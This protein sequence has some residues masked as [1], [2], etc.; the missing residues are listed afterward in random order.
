M[1]WREIGLDPVK[2]IITSKYWTTNH[3]LGKDAK[4]QQEFLVTSNK[5]VI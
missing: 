3:F 1:F 5:K 2:W 4:K